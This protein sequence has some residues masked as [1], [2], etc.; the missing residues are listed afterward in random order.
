[1]LKTRIIT[2]VFL[3]TFTL[4]FLFNS[5][6]S[7]W[8]TLLLVVAGIAAWEWAGFVKNST[9]SYKIGVVTVTVLM[10][11]G[12]M[13]FM[14]LWVLL[15]MVFV[16]T[17]V[18]VIT[19]NRYQVSKA[20]V[21]LDNPVF[22]YFSGILSV[23]N[24]AVALFW[25]RELYSPTIVLFLMATIWAIDTG[26]YFSG[27]QFGKRKLAE[28]VSPGKTWEGVIGGGV[29]TSLLVILGWYSQW[30]PV[31][32]M[33]TLGVVFGVLILTMVA[34]ISVYGDLFESV[35]KRQVGIKDSGK[36]LPG[37]GGVLD[38]VDSLI[39]AMPLFLV[40]LLLVA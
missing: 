2:A 32:L 8:G 3:A 29:L 17:F 31:G 19:V 14:H 25:I 23:V 18:T 15:P 7:N 10:S 30:L 26:A 36:I 21:G 9:L 27:R 5:T 13:S 11:W 20:K 35:L 1:M 22:I 34:L 28:F 39:I 12:L 33:D 40:I 24:L 6:T 37:H 4:L 38:R 16:Q